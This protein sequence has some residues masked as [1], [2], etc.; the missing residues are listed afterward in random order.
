MTNKISIYVRVFVTQ[1]DIANAKTPSLIREHLRHWGATSRGD[2]WY[3]QVSLAGALNSKEK[4]AIFYAVNGSATDSTEV[5]S[6]LTVIYIY[7]GESDFDKHLI[8]KIYRTAEVDFDG[9][10]SVKSRKEKPTVRFRGCLLYTSPSPRDRTRS[11]M[12]SSA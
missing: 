6:S 12:P 7:M 10:I 5:D 4:Q 8:S 9:Y 1:E 2:N 11:R 3:E